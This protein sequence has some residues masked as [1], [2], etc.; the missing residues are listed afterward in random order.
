MLPLMRFFSPKYIVDMIEYMLI[1]FKVDFISFMDET[2]LWD[3]KRTYSI[4]DLLEERD[5][6]GTFNWGCLGRV[7]NVNEELLRR[8]KESR[9][10]YIS[11]GY[12]SSNQGMLDYLRKGN[13]VEQQQIALDITKKAEIQPHTTYMIGYPGET[14][15][16]LYD[17]ARFMVKN[18]ITVAPFFLTPYIYTELYWEN[19]EKI[20]EQYD[21]DEEKFVRACGDAHAFVVNLTERFTDAELLAFQQMISAGDLRRLREHGAWRASEGLDPPSEEIIDENPPKSKMVRQ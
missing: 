19:K 14:M 9:C 13:T 3:E 5:L 8:L 7:E 12:E 4:L 11:Y 10:T 17:S 15:Q 1:H 21:G 20:L 16:T 2:F 18:G 6:I